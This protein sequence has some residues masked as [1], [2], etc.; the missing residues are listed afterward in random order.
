[1]NAK[2]KILKFE[3]DI[4]GLIDNGKQNQINENI[5]KFI[6]EQRHIKDGISQLYGCL[7]LG[8]LEFFLG[9]KS[10]LKSTIKSLTNQSDKFIY[11]KELGKEYDSSTQRIDTD[12]YGLFYAINDHFS[13]KYDSDSYQ[14]LKNGDL[15]NT[16]A[17]NFFNIFL[18][19][20]FG[21]SNFITEENKFL[22]KRIEGNNELNQKERF[23]IE[24]T[25]KLNVNFLKI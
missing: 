10:E 8:E 4:I 12:T 5:K 2:D 9:D 22:F 17:T 23:F 3:N 11:V 20:S 1:M 13:K 25:S 21:N 14:V 24:L 18:K 6:E 16:I 7:L 19:D 15:G